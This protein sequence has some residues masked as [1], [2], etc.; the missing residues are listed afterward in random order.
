MW[1]YI[2]SAV[3]WCLGDIL[4]F[5]TWGNHSV[6]SSMYSHV[7]THWNLWPCNRWGPW[8]SHWAQCGQGL[9][10]CYHCSPCT[11]L[12]LGVVSWSHVNVC[13]LSRASL[14]P[15]PS[16]QRHLS[17]WP[18]AQIQEELDSSSLRNLIMLQWI[19]VKYKMEDFFFVGEKG[20]KG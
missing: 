6:E 5:A 16:W 15:L 18:L 7:R 4:G 14:T 20:R 19:Y 17:W 13:E 11:C 12:W 3:A 9:Y 10:W 1:T 8:A 2:V